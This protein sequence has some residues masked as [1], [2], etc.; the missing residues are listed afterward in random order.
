LASSTIERDET[1]FS[2]AVLADDCQLLKKTLVWFQAEKTTPNQNILASD[3]PHDKRIRL[4]DLMGWPSDFAAWRRLI[5]FLLQQINNLPAALY[6]D[7]L[8]VF[9]VWQNALAGIKNRVSS[10]IIT[11]CADWLGDIDKAGSRKATREPSRW[12][13]LEELDDF[14][15]SLGRLIFRSAGPYPTF[16]EEYLKRIIALERLRG[17]RLSAESRH[18]QDSQGDICRRGG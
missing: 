1:A 11:Q 9:E 16:T 6:P 5:D 13:E 12:S 15:K 7:I 4:A 17:D 14:R 18:A 3:M 2:K 10:V 8:S